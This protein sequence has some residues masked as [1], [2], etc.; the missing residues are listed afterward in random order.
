MRSSQAL[1]QL[2]L[3]FPLQVRLVIL[4]PILFL[5]SYVSYSLSLQS[6][7]YLRAH[8]EIASASRR[9]AD[10]NATEEA[11]ETMEDDDDQEEELGHRSNADFSQS[12]A[13]RRALLASPFTY[14]FEVRVLSLVA[15]WSCVFHCFLFVFCSV[16]IF[17]FAFF[18]LSLRL[19]P[20][21]D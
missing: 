19:L 21:S 16:F 6:R 1:Q 11:E 17:S 12:G 3:S 18:F 9:S 10:A 14:D 7:L 8:A 5:R 15:R 2:A 13:W 20:P 4:P